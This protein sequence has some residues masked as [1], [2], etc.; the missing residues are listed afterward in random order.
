MDIFAR[1]LV[2]QRDIYLSGDITQGQNLQNVQGNFL[3]SHSLP[4]PCRYFWRKV[5][6]TDGNYLRIPNMIL[7]FC[8]NNLFKNYYKKTKNQLGN[9]E[10]YFHVK[11]TKQH[12]KHAQSKDLIKG[13]YSI[14]EKIE[15]TKKLNVLQRIYF[16]N[17]RQKITKKCGYPPLSP[18][19]Y[20]SF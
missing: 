17:F 18:P 3:K 19:P 14:F 11:Q 7:I 9:F 6:Q 1:L 10:K 13:T 4:L 5:V 2:Y 20:M 8:K 16:E 15:K 12:R